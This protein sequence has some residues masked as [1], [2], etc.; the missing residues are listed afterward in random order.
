MPIAINTGRPASAASGGPRTTT[1]SRRGGRTRSRSPAV[2]GGRPPPPAAAEGMVNPSSAAA[3]AAAAA[4]AFAGNA[5]AAPPRS[6][7]PENEDYHPANFEKQSRWPPPS[8]DP[9]RR[10]PA[11]YPARPRTSGAPEE[12]PD[13]RYRP[14]R[15][16]PNYDRNYA[17]QQQQYP[18]P[19]VDY[20]YDRAMGKTP[21]PAQQRMGT[22]L[23]LGGC[24]PIHVPKTAP[25]EQQRGAASVF[26]GRPNVGASSSNNN[27]ADD[28]GPPKKLL[29]LQTPTSSFDDT[30]PSRKGLSLSPAD[31]PVAQHAHKEDPLLEKSPGGSKAGLIDMTPSFVLFN[32]SFDSF[33]D[34][35]YFNVDSSFHADSFGMTRTASVE[36]PDGILLKKNS[37]IGTQQLLTA[38]SGALTIGFSPVNSFGNA[39]APRGGSN[40]MVLDGRSPSPTQVLGMYRSYSGGGRPEIMD[41]PQLRLNG[42]NSS[43]GGPH[44]SFGGEA[45]PYLGPHPHNGEPSFYGLLRKYKMAFKHC[46]FLLPGLKIALL[47]PPEKM[48]AKWNAVRHCDPDF[49]TI[50]NRLF[51]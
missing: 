44:R 36:H 26:R 12:Y 48:D 15:Y 2:T 21:P 33:G 31:L 6:A 40:M 29:S 14:H 32:Q 46:T 27:K 51:D 37:S 18:P 49:F 23:V 47:E 42:S 11:H 10:Y 19:A 30:K 28:E 34:G 1:T 50:T 8:E 4:K 24:T 38:G 41:D 22:S 13:R 9:Y 5:A 20:R 25:Y 43:F 3:A 7:W 16:D 17:R 45:F 35:N 39:S